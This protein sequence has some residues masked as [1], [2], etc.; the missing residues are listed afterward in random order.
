MAQW[1]KD[2]V[3]SLQQLGLLLWDEFDLWP[4]NFN[5]PWMQPKKKQ[6]FRL[7]PSNQKDT[8]VFIATILT[9]TL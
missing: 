9:F 2:L 4:G 8:T 1:V 5:M 3:P 6:S 7:L